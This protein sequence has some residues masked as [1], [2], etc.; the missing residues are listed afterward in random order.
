MRFVLRLGHQLGD[1]YQRHE[2]GTCYRDSSSRPLPVPATYAFFKH[3]VLLQ[4]QKVISATSC[5]NF[6]LFEFE[7]RQS[8]P[9]YFQCHIVC[10]ALAN[11]PNYKLL[12]FFMRF[13]PATCLLFMEYT[14]RGLFPLHVSV[15][16]PLKCPDL[17]I[18]FLHEH[19]PILF[20]NMECNRLVRVHVYVLTNK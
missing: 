6:S 19:V 13:V 14:R 2:A 4:G 12:G 15:T 11:C 17:Y 10:T 1:M 20:R 3:K 9:N 18:S 16:L 8:D 7:W 5:M